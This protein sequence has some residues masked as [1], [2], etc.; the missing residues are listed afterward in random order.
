MEIQR[1]DSEE[2]L[3][4][5]VKSATIDAL[6]AMKAG[7]D[8]IGGAIER[9]AWGTEARTVVYRFRQSTSQHI[10]FLRLCRIVSGLHAV[11]VLLDAG[12]TQEVG[13][14]ARTLDEFCSDI[15]FLDEAHDGRGSPK[16]QQRFVDEFF[17]ETRLTLD[18]RLEADT[19]RRV[20]PREKVRAAAARRLNEE[21]P[22][23]A[24]G[25]LK[26]IEAVTGGF[27]HGSY[28]SVMEM[29]DPEEGRF[30]VCG[31]KGTPRVVEMRRQ[32]AIY[33][34][35]GLNLM[36]GF[37]SQLGLPF[38]REELTAARMAFERSEAYRF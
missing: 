14:L 5:A 11:Q 32:Q 29:Y 15:H 31:M 22:H 24:R 6:E 10:V 4:L 2:A 23:T 38:A 19:K 35:Q 21:D 26:A 9:P 8:R 16:Q 27:V 28:L 20:F 17:A 37:A 1:P 7:L 3:G 33:I 30:R 18:E 13:V 34:H 36:V 12:F 25:H